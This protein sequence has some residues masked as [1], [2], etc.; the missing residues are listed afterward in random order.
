ME[1][2]KENGL[3]GGVCAGI[4]DELNISPVL[5]RLGFLGA[6]A[7]F[8]MGPLIYLVLWVIMP[9]KSA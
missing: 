6:F 7:F 2:N 8:G 4:A 9:K 5:V 3:I 1:R